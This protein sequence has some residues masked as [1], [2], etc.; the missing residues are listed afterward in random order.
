MSVISK[1]PYDN[2][3]VGF[4]KGS[5]ERIKSISVDNSIPDSFDK[6]LK[7]YTQDGLRVLA[8]AY[9]YLPDATYQQAKGLDREDIE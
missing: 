6:I 8:L 9:K 1:N 2:E 5:P 4:V 3:L 7:N